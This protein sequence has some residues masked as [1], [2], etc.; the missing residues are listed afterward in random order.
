ML[1]DE[2]GQTFPFWTFATASVLAMMLFVLNYS[3][4]TA[5]NLRAQDA[6]DSAAAGDVSVAANVANEETTLAY[7]AAVAEYRL[8]IL[9]QAIL[10]TIAHNGGCTATVGGTCEQNYNVLLAAFNSTLTSLQNDHQMLQRANQFQQGGQQQAQAKAASIA[11]G[12]QCGTG[13]GN[14]CG[15]AYTILAGSATGSSTTEVIACRN[16]PYVATSLLGIKS[17]TFQ[18]VGHSASGVG[19]G[20]TETFHPAATNPQTGAAYQPTETSWNGQTLPYQVPAYTVSYGTAAA[21]T[22]AVQLN[23][24][25]AM[26]IRPTMSVTAG[27]YTCN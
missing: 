25:Q 27:S 12:S 6:A 4:T 8:R 11:T 21:P 26:P 13:S 3:A 5:W 24:Y 23:W 2:R 9:N 14:E 15:F 7:A 22:L 18:A 1:G 20:A 19:I 16:V 10:N 17:P